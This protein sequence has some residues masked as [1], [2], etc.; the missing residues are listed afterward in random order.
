MVEQGG[1]RVGEVVRGL[2]GAEVSLTFSFNYKASE[3]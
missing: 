1:E 3:Y 2:D